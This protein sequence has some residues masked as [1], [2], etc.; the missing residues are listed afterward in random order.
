MTK[1]PLKDMKA[2]LG[3]KKPLLSLVPPAIQ[4]YIARRLQFGG[5][6]YLQTGNYLREAEGMDDL[7]RFKEYLSGVRRHILA[8]ED[9]IVR[10]QA[11]GRG[12]AATA[13]DAVGIIDPEVGDTMMGGA[14]ASLAIAMQVGVDAGFLP[15]DPGCPWL[16]KYEPTQVAGQLI[17]KPP[18]TNLFCNI[19]GEPLQTLW[20]DQPMMCQTCV[21]LGL[22]RD[23]YP[24]VEPF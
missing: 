5:F 9:A 1:A 8:V 24:R 18:P 12:H 2:A 19:H 3:G 14:C 16:E 7:E 15:A 23:A 21:E 6:K 10:F 13:A 22:G 20:K 4:V 11:K 17:P